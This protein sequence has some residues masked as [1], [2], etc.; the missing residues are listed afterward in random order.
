MGPAVDEKQ[1]Q[2]DLSYIQVA[3]AEGARLL[4]GGS[5]PAHLSGGYFVAPTIFDD[6]TPAMRIFREEVFGPVLGVTTAATLADAIRAANAVEYGLTA[7][8]F[9]QDLDSALRFVEESETGMV[10]VLSLIHI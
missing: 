3:Q 1:W 8:I 7:S 2:T 4:T 10:H 9:T 6:V 5:R